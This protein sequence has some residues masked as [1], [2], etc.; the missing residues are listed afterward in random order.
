GGEIQLTDAIAALMQQET[1]NAF[2]MSGSSHDCGSKLGYM[3]ANVEYATQ[4]GE[5]GDD[6]K[7]AL[8]QFV[9]KMD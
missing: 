8:R 9:E 2:H 4:H 3:M 1:V 5:L 7:A 6:F